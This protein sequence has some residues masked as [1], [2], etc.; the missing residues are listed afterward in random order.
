VITKGPTGH[1]SAPTVVLAIVAAAAALACE[2]RPPDAGDYVANLTAERQAKDAQFLAEDDPVP[3]SR[4]AQLLP[5]A[6]FPIDPEYNVPAS[7]RLAEEQTI[8]EMPTS[9]GTLRRQRVVGTMEFILK[10]EPHKLLATV[11]A[12]AADVNHVTVMFSDLTSGA[13]TYPAG[14]Y[15]DLVRNPHGVYQLDFNRAYNPYC[16]YNESY[17][18]PYPPPENRM[19]VPIRAGEGLKN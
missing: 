1:R 17:E 12:D 18:C 4:K 6:Y 8:V 11:D 19:P 15:I 5:L 10:G 9:T 7:L 14:R 13:E 2:S 16:Y 3:P